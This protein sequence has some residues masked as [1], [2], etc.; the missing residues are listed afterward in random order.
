MKKTIFF[1]VSAIVLA[2]CGGSNNNQ[3][4]PQKP[5]TQSETT[6]NKP[7]SGGGNQ[8][9]ISGAINENVTWKDLGLPVDYIVEGAVFLDGN[10]LVTV[11]PG[12][13][14]MFS[15]VD[16]HIY[17]GEN[18]GIK[19]QGT[20]DKPIVLTC[21]LNNQNVGAWGNLSIRSTRSDNALEF[22]EFK[23][24]GAGSN[25][26]DIAGTVS[27]KNCTIDGAN[28]NGISVASDGKLTAFE[29]NTMKNCKQYPLVIANNSKLNGIGAGNVFESNA[30]N[31][32]FCED[33]YF[34]DDNFKYAVHK[35][36]VP[37]FFNDGFEIYNRVTVTIEPGVKFLFNRNT[38]CSMS[39]EAIVKIQGTDS[40]PVVFDG[41]E[42]KAGYWEGV[43]YEANEKDNV[44][45][46]F[47][48]VNAGKSGANSLFIGCD[49]VLT[50]KNVSVTKGEAD[51]AINFDCSE[52]ISKLKME[53]V[54]TDKGIVVN[55]QEEEMVF[56]TVD[57]MLK[58]VK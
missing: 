6:E 2:S 22:V 29:N 49:A 44:F 52:N 33:R 39:G 27:V 30:Q 35:T 55:G 34:G 57:E 50:M 56:K 23:N 51:A 40:E 20:K 5:E 7:I 54:T 3:N 4:N 16:G 41:L 25:V 8:V 15:G 11:E 24:G 47:N 58:K 21:P 10:S 12:V 18:A 38:G 9:T 1:A 13:T 42:D 19:M 31:V 36:A 32:I 43:R 37:Y 48:I 14:I 17:V 26:L 45:E 46:N 53:N 28:E